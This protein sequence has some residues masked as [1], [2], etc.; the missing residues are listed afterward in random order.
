M[1]N[2]CVSDNFTVTDGVLGL[3]RSAMPRVVAENVTQ[4][5]GDGPI[6]QHS[7]GSAPKIFIESRTHWVNDFGADV[8]VQVQIQRARRTAYTTNPHMVFLRERVTTAVG[9]DG[10]QQVR[11]PEPEVYTTWDTEWG[12][13]DFI[14]WKEGEGWPKKVT[15]MSTPQATSTLNMILV[16]AGHALDVRF[17]CALITDAWSNIPWGDVEKVGHFEHVAQML[18]FSNVTRLLALPVPV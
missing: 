9:R 14:P 1:A 2:L 13:G 6:T 3:A 8:L 16:P 12:G 7:T 4:S 17:R 11:A 10:A 15:V 5:T 18:A